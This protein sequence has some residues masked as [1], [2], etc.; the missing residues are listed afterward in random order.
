MWWYTTVLSYTI[1]FL[2]VLLLLGIMFKFNSTV[3]A[4]VTTVLTIVSVI[5]SLTVSGNCSSAALVADG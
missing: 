5:Q 2:V 4:F 3:L 1:T